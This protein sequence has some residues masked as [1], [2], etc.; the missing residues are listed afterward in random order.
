M[1]TSVGRTGK[2]SPRSGRSRARRYDRRGW[3]ASAGNGERGVRDLGSQRHPVLRLERDR[4]AA[5]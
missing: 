3:S 2:I 5:I 4:I 1:W